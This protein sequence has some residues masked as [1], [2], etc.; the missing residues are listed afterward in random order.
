MV[1]DQS[2][3][4]P[5]LVGSLP[6]WVPDLTV[7]LNPDPL[8]RLS[9]SSSGNDSS[10]V[11]LWNP[12]DDYNA[13]VTNPA[14]IDGRLLCVKGAMFETI[15]QVSILIATK[16]DSFSWEQVLDAFRPQWAAR[17]SGT[18]FMDALWR[19]LI[20]NMQKPGGSLPA[21]AQFG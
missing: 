10:D 13:N 12:C 8:V 14:P 11:R 3:R 18:A 19:T 21:N 6:S 16:E 9:P 15:T 1:E 20:A 7:P 4:H 5:D 17:V 2:R